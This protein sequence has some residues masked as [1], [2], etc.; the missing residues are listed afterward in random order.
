MVGQND[1]M[2]PLIRE[3]D[4]NSKLIAMNKPIDPKK[5]IHSN[6]YLSLAVKKNSISE[7]KLSE[8]TSAEVS[9]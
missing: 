7:G 3:L 2:Y 5:V 9:E 4:Y 6:H 8:E 1:A